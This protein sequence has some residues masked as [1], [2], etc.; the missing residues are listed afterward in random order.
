MLCLQFGLLYQKIPVIKNKSAILML[1]SSEHLLIL[2]A[3][4]LGI[5]HEHGISETK[6]SVKSTTLI[7]PESSVSVFQADCIRVHPSKGE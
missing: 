6:K 5:P 1:K 4:S 2:V 7:A 3:L